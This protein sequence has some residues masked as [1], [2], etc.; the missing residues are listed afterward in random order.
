MISVEYI[1]AGIAAE[2]G[3]A[4]N[5]AQAARDEAYRAS[6]YTGKTTDVIATTPIAFAIPYA[7][8][9]VVDEPRGGRGRELGDDVERPPRSPGTGS[10]VS[11]S[12]AR[13][14]GQLELVARR[15]RRL[16][17]PRLPGVERREQHERGHQREH[18][19]T[20]AGGTSRGSGGP[21]RCPL[22][23]V[24]APWPSARARRSDACRLAGLRASAARRR[25]RDRDEDLVHAR[26]SRVSAASPRPQDP[27]SLPPR[28]SRGRR[29]GT[30]R[31]GVA[32]L[33]LARSLRP[34]RPA[35]TTRT[36]P[37]VWAA[38]PPAAGTRRTHQRETGPERGRED[39]RR[40]GRPAGSRRRSLIATTNPTAAS[41]ASTEAIA[42]PRGR[43]RCVPP[44]AAVD[45]ERGRTRR[46]GGRQ[47]GRTAMKVPRW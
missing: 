27:H 8:A 34:A 18:P 38:R 1:S 11:A 17:T 28:R 42:T 43:G 16:A 3:A 31:P 2:P 32:C 13:D 6:R 29:P 7:G 4:A 39:R 37:P 14:L 9:R 20:R 26:L 12:G 23:D 19:P 44:G 5:S 41:V 22:G 30:R 47:D 36:R 10:P 21:S 33:E 24:G 40:A 45:P 46:T 35:P 25:I 15:R